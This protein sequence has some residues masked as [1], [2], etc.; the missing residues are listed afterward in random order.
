VG[1]R[2]EPPLELVSGLHTVNC[3]YMNVHGLPDAES[4]PA[5]LGGWK[6]DCS[7]PAPTR[8]L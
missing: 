1:V 8:L 3:D 5:Q 7:R 6:Y 2:R 4:V